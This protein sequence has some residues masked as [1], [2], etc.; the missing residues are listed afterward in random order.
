MRT[1]KMLCAKE[2]SREL[3]SKV[4]LPSVSVYRVGVGFKKTAEMLFSENPQDFDWVYP[5]I[6][7][8]S[9]SIEIFLKSCLAEDEYNEFKFGVSDSPSELATGFMY[10]KSDVDDRDKTHD[11]AD[12]FSKLSQERSKIIK[13]E[14]QKTSMAKKYPK[15]G[16]LLRDLNGL[17]E[18]A[19]YGYSSPDLLP[20]NLSIIIDTAHFFEEVIPKLEGIE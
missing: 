20:R 5:F 11:L 12:L 1:N 8:A 7:N 17:F 3:N 13:K 14:Y 10:I 16:G 19:R 15:I 6:A 9:F 18:A 4:P 2:G